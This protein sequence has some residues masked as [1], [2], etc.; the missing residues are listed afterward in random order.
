MFFQ[1][2]EL[3][4][5]FL[6]ENRLFFVS[7]L[8]VSEFYSPPSKVNQALGLRSLAGQQRLHSCSADLLFF[9]SKFFCKPEHKCYKLKMWRPNKKYQARI[10]ILSVKIQILQVIFNYCFIISI[11]NLFYFVNFIFDWE[12]QYICFSYTVC[13]KQNI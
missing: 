9:G 4:L 1:A 11:Y 5:K 13:S 10:K 6:H 3:I 7:V 12:N 2:T 8:L